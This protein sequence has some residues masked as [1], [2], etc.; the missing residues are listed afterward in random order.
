MDTP[1]QSVESKVWKRKLH[2]VETETC[3]QFVLEAIL[4]ATKNQCV[5][6]PVKDVSNCNA[7]E[8]VL[9]PNY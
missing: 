2:H 8:E 4:S 1:V 9:S 3:D 7:N 5:E 6:S